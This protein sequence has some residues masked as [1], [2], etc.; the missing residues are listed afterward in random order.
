MHVRPQ[1]SGSRVLRSLHSRGT[2]LN[3]DFGGVAGVLLP[4]QHAHGFA[5]RAFGVQC[6]FAQCGGGVEQ[7]DRAA[8]EHLSHNVL[9]FCRVRGA[10]HVGDDAAGAG[11]LNGCVQ[12]LT[13]QG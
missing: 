4:R 11:R 6:D 13:L 8:F 9:G 2:L 1:L 5:V 12:E 3:L 10:G 7:A